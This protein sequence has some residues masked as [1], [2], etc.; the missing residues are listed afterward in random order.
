MTNSADNNGLLERLDYLW[1]EYEYRHSLVWNL[2]F[3]FTSAIVL[4]SIVPYVQIALVKTLGFFILLAPILAF[5]LA[6]FSLPVMDKELKLL[7]KIR[8]VYREWQNQLPLQ[9]PP[10][11]P[12]E[13][14]KEGIRFTDLVLGYLAGLAFLSLINVRGVHRFGNRVDIVD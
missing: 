6:V 12:P 5:G 4:I 13:E 10:F 8:E 11:H 3:R 7:G 2:I 1:K 14:E 9:D